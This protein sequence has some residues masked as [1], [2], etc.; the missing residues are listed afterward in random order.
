MKSEPKKEPFSVAIMEKCVDQGIDKIRFLKRVRLQKKVCY[1][2]RSKKN[3]L[4][5][6]QSL[7]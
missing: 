7:D 2:S 6:T 1:L 5:L 4:S 3:L